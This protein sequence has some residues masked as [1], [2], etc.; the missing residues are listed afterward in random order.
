[1]TLFPGDLASD[2]ALLSGNLQPPTAPED[3]M[4]FTGLWGQLHSQVHAHRQMHTH[5]H[6]YVLNGRWVVHSLI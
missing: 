1:M 6:K 4:A 2:P 3:L 5:A